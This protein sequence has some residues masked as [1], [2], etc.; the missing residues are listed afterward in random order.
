MLTAEK[1]RAAENET[2]FFTSMETAKILGVTQRTFYNL[3]NN[4]KL[5]ADFTGTRWRVSREALQEYVDTV[6]KR[7]SFLKGRRGS[8]TQRE[9]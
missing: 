4:G 5:K 1:N 7:K 9:A 2:V 3:I 8:R 6:T